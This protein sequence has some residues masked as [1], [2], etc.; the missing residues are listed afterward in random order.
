MTKLLEGKEENRI[1][2]LFAKY[3]EKQHDRLEPPD[4][5]EIIQLCDD[6]R[7]DVWQLS[8]KSF[9]PTFSHNKADRHKSRVRPTEGRTDRP[10]DR[11]SGLYSR[12]HATKKQL[13]TVF[14][15]I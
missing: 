9:I 14:L 7:L 1:S 4:V 13:K 10:T 15:G 5:E 8:Q 3:K 2:K 6:Y 12:V 11:Q